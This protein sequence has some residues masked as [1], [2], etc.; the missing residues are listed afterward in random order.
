MPCT[1][2]EPH[3][4]PTE[5]RGASWPLLFL[6]ASA[7]QI[8]RRERAAL[9]GRNGQPLSL[10]LEEPGQIENLPDVIRRVG[11]RTQACLADAHRLAAD[12]NRPV[13]IEVGQTRERVF[14]RAPARI[15]AV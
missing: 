14:K 4:R 2:P 15:P 13:E 11:D 3:R 6:R 1:S 5:T 10:G 8:G 12:G 7:W 9:A